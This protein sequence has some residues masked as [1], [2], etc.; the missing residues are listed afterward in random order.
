MVTN[1][2]DGPL[3]SGS[4]WDRLVLLG[5]GVLAFRSFACAFGALLLLHVWMSR[6]V[7]L[8]G[9]FPVGFWGPVYDWVLV[10]T[11]VLAWQRLIRGLGQFKGGFLPQACTW[12]GVGWAG[13]DFVFSEI[14]TT[15]I[16]LLGVHLFAMT[17]R[18]WVNRIQ[19][20]R[21]GYLLA[22]CVVALSY[23]QAALDK[24]VLGPYPWSWMMNCHL[25]TLF[26]S[27]L[28]C[29][30]LKEGA[31]EGPW[32]AVLETMRWM[33]PV[34]C[35]AVLVLQL[36]LPWSLLQR[37]WKSM[38]L[39]ALVAFH[40]LVYCLSGLFLGHWLFFLLLLCLLPSRGAIEDESPV[41]PSATQAGMM[42]GLLLSL[43][44]ARWQSQNLGWF[45]S[46]AVESVVLT[47]PS[48][49][50]SSQGVFPASWYLSL[51]S[52]KILSS[53][54]SEKDWDRWLAMESADGNT[55]LSAISREGVDT[56]SSQRWGAWKALREL[57]QGS[58]AGLAY[59][60]AKFGPPEPYARS[61]ILA[62]RP[63]PLQGSILTL[64][65]TRGRYQNLSWTIDEVETFELE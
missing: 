11:V 27:Q 20:S 48:G 24:L 32:R 12:L 21:D 2:P 44:L 15:R 14:H 42:A 49:H 7:P 35:F 41:M 57:P 51:V 16:L 61:M 34:F 45:P 29:H 60:L 55:M 43:L 31:V 5:L 1:D 3:P 17:R 39:W 38:A 65:V 53:S 54:A 6:F 28:G 63:E 36:T 37:R 33:S 64:H 30:F 10:M 47:S 50:Q 8:V 56:F 23:F 9:R 59:I 46:A 52:T 58:V 4:V 19:P 40:V 13:L 18:D 26:V 25:D 22:I 62:F